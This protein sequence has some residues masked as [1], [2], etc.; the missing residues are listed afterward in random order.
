LK[1]ENIPDSSFFAF[2]KV[3]AYGGVYLP[4]RSGSQHENIKTAGGFWEISDILPAVFACVNEKRW[5]T[6]WKSAKNR[7]I[8]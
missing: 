3:T 2:C 5:R 6:E 1:N 4:Q 7:S 8:I